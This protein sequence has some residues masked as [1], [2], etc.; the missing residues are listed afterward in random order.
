LSWAETVPQNEVVEIEA[1]LE[2]WMVSADSGERRGTTDLHHFH[3][4]DRKGWVWIEDRQDPVV[5]LSVVVAEDG[6]GTALSEWVSRCPQP[7]IGRLETVAGKDAVTLHIVDRFRLPEQVMDSRLRFNHLIMTAELV[8]PLVCTALA[9]GDD[10]LN[11]MQSALFG[12]GLA[13]PPL[14]DSLRD[15]LTRIG[16]WHWCTALVSRADLYNFP[17][18]AGGPN[19]G[20]D[21]RPV[22]ALAHVGHGVNSYALSLLVSKGPVCAFFQLAWGGLYMDPIGSGEQIASVFLRLHSLFGK[23]EDQSSPARYLMR[24]S[25]FEHEAT[26]GLVDLDDP[27][28]D[29]EYKDMD[30]LFTAVAAKLR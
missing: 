11:D 5:N 16:K 24:Y 12:A 22:F 1:L 6:R 13:P 14:P 10:A 4:R 2:A 18:L 29:E 28:A 26:F 15:G 27:A 3:N 9:R 21:R 8:S 30:L 19:A 17:R 25:D 7:L 23:L 20:W